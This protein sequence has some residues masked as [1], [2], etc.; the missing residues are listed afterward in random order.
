MEIV[1]EYTVPIIIALC[2][3]VGY[4]VKKWVN[5]VSNKWIPTICMILGVFFNVWLN[6]WAITPE[7]LLGGFASGLAATGFDQ[8]LR[9]NEYE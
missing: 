7:I 6:N 4:I 3:C 8:L 2:F 1:Q 5:D 9:T